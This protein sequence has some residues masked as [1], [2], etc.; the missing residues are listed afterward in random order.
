M[1]TGR[2]TITVVQGEFAVSSD[3][4]SVMSTVLGS[5]ISVC[6]CDPV[7]GIGGMNHFLLAMA[8]DG[9]GGD[10]KYGVNAMELLI[11]RMLRQG[12]VRDRMQAKVFGGAR[13]TPHGQDIGGSNAAFALDFLAQEGIPVSAKSVGGTAARRIQFQPVTGAARQM[14][15][16]DGLADLPVAPK[17]A[18]P[19]APQITLF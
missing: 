8:R 14:Q 13:M 7:T 16:T 4:S 5:C 15:V 3:A 2:R 18:P 17:P 11:N 19:P 9:G 10:L 12:A 6:L 1:T